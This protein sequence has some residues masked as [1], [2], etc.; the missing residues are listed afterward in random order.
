MRRYEFN[1]SGKSELKCGI[2]LEMIVT[3]G[4]AIG[5]YNGEFSALLTSEKMSEVLAGGSDQDGWPLTVVE[6]YVQW[7]VEF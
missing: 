3:C 2:S 7:A 4:L 6:P 5:F 1:V